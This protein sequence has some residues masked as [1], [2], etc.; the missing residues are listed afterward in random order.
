MLGNLTVSTRHIRKEEGTDVG[1]RWTWW[2]NIVGN[3]LTRRRIRMKI[4]YIHRPQLS[5]TAMISEHFPSQPRPRP[6]VS[7]EL[8]TLYLMTFSFYW[9]VPSL[10]TL[11]WRVVFP[12]SAAGV[13]WLWTD[14]PLTNAQYPVDGRHTTSSIKYWNCHCTNR[15][16][17]WKLFLKLPSRHCTLVTKLNSRFKHLKPITS[18]TH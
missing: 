4:Y 3:K 16:L 14:L 12:V 8:F 5:Y 18:V 17:L 10:S 7:A 1:W 11:T 2:K 6:V 9:V 13:A 15:T